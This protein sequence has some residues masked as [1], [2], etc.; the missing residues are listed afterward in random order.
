MNWLR[1]YFII[2]GVTVSV[3]GLCF[4]AMA[5]VKLVQP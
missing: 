1:D 5:I 2:A 4:A 3:F